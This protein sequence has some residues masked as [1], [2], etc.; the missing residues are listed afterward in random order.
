MEG[1]VAVL[2]AAAGAGLVAVAVTIAIERW[3]GRVGG[4]LGTM[5]TTIVPASLGILAGA[6]DL[7]A[8]RHAMDLAPW[9]MALNA[10]FLWLWRALPPRL[11]PWSLG[12]RLAAMAALS[13]AAWLAGALALVLAGRAYLGA[14]L[15]SLALGVSG[16]AALLVVGVLATLRSR[17][18]P[19]GGRR[20]SAAA[21]AARGLL[22]A[23]AIGLAVWLARVGG[24]LAAGMVSVFP[25]IFLTTMVS[26]WLAQGEAV[27]A[28]AVGP[29]MLGSSSVATFAVLA[30]LGMPVLGPAAGAA[31]AWVAAVLTTTL[32]AHLWLSRR[33]A[34]LSGAGPG[35]GRS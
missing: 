32:P 8:F 1:A 3:G 20:V 25:A 21:V 7:E 13:L 23:S 18:S 5:P 15:P 16:A 17:P 28:G 2:S 12:A 6:P 35:P 11:P 14:G 29:M 30:R 22:A 19:R 9:G 34:R 10:C 27:P 31:V 24:P 33:A 4:I 26:L